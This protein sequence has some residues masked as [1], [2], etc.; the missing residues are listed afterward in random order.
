M[1]PIETAEHR[2]VLRHCRLDDAFQ[3]GP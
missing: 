2:H 3:H 1:P